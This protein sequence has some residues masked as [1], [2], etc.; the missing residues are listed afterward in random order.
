MIRNHGWDRD[1]DDE[2]QK[3]LRK[4]WNIDDFESLYTFYLNGFNFR[5]TDLQ[6]YIGLGQIKKIKDISEKRNKNF[7]FIIIILK[8]LLNIEIRDSNFISNFAYPILSKEKDIVKELTK[9]NIETRPLISGS[10]GNQPFYV[11]DYGVNML[12]NASLIDKY[13]IYMQTILGLRRLI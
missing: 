13:G 10:I 11:K 12:K 5:S 9:N 7:F 8:N 4:K 6:A 3:A 2:S 1:L